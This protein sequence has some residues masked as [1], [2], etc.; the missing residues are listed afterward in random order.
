MERK[1]DFRAEL[2]D[3]LEEWNYKE[4]LEAYDRLCNYEEEYFI[5]MFLIILDKNHLY[6]DLF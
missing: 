2:F 3:D 5:Y 4:V 6:A 1:Q